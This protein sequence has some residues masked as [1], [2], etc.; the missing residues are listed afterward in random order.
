MAEHYA[1]RLFGNKQTNILTGADGGPIKAEV[2]MIDALTA[3]S[4]ELK[5]K[6]RGD[7]YDG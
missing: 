6:E 7:G 2:S 4:A 5:N 3:L 1:P